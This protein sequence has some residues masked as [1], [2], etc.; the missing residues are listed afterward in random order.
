MTKIRISMHGT[1]VLA[2]RL[3]DLIPTE[4]KV[5]WDK[6]C[7]CLSNG[8]TREII[9]PE[10]VIANPASFA[11]RSIS[12][13]CY[14]KLRKSIEANPDTNFLI[15]CNEEDRRSSDKRHIIGE[16]E[17]VHYI[18]DVPSE[19]HSSRFKELLKHLTPLRYSS[20]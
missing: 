7:L 16:Y 4:Y 15:Y 6:R 20:R 9:L 1:N 3:N 13:S 10:I 18:P 17:N 8:S 12:R 2:D 19:R 11:D 5:Y 14:F